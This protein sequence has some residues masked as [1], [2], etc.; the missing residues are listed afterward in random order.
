MK[1]SVLLVG[2]DVGDLSYRSFSEHEADSK[3]LVNTKVRKS[4][5]CHSDI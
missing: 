5:V 3:L 4:N 1:R 2:S